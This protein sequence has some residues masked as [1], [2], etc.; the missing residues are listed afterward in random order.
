MKLPGQICQK[1]E[2]FNNPNSHAYTERAQ[3]AAH[4]NI[5]TINWCTT[6]TNCSTIVHGPKADGEG[7]KFSFKRP[8][9]RGGDVAGKHR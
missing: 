8:R 1:L 3:S 2:T 9:C 6:L 7:E 5:K 4:I